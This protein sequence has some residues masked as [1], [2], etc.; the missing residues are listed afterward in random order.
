MPLELDSLRTEELGAIA[1]HAP[2][3]G[4]LGEVCAHLVSSRGKQLRAR[5]LLAA[6]RNG[7]H[8]E[9]AIVRSAA[10]AVEAI[11]LASLTH[12]D[13]I[14]EGRDRRGVP[15][16]VALFGNRRAA[17]AGN[18]LVG[19]SVQLVL[20]SGSEAVR[21]FSDAAIALTDGEMREVA[22]LYDTECTPERYL[23]TVRRKTGALFWLAARLGGL[24]AGAE[25]RVLDS[26]ERYGWELGITYQIAD[27]LLDLL[28]MKGIPDKTGRDLCNGVYTLPVIHAIGQSEH[29]RL[30]LESH[31]VY[32]DD[33]VE[34]V[35][36]IVRATGAVER[37]LDDFHYHAESAR[38]ALRGLPAPAGL[39]TILDYVVCH[40]A[41]VA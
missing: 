39:E 5:V 22:G 40:C 10:A 33:L 32:D 15:T 35:I 30:L 8:P 21:A 41:E 11:H 34:Q 29:L 26:L 3:G 31:A 36:E 12:D 6:A 38:T 24:L 13:V 14:D 2:E 19:R 23:E 18:W 1:E 25:S 20:R 7:A 37:T 27:D 9:R 17:I 4:G 16:A 28:T